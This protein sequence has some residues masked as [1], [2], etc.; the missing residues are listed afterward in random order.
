MR[1]AVPPSIVIRAWPPARIRGPSTIP[2]SIASRS[3][4]PMFHR[5]SAS[6]TLVTPARSTLRAL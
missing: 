2:A 5:Q 1:P 3:S 6:S 4:Q